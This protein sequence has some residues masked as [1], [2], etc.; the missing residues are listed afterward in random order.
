MSNYKG[1][2][3]K[4]EKVIPIEKADNIQ[5]AVVLGEFTIVSKTAKEGDVGILFP[6]GTQLSEQYCHENNLFRDSSK[7]KDAE[8]AGFFD[9]NRKV[10]C[11]KFLGVKSEAYF[12]TLESVAY[13]GVDISALTP[14]LCF[15]ELNGITICTKFLSEKAKKEKLVKQNKPKVKSVPFFKE[16]VETEQFKYNL[17]KINKGDLISIQSKRHGT[18]QRSGIQLV[19]K[20]LPKWKQHVNKFISLFKAGTV[21]EHVVGTRRVVLNTP[22][23]D[24][25]HGSEAFR[26]EIA[27]LILPFLSEGVTVY[28]EVYGWANG[29]TIMP[30]HN[31]EAIK[32]KEYQKKYGK[33][34]TYSYGCLEGTYGFH[35]YRV[36]YTTNSGEIVDLTQQ[37]LVK[38]CT[39]RGLNPALDVVEPFI[40]DG[41][42][43]KLKV[44]VEQLTER[45]EVLT[46]DYTDPKHVSEGV[47]VRIDRGPTTPLFL[48]SKSF[49]FRCLEGH[50]QDTG[51][52]DLEEVS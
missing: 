10:R 27:N 25:F 30:K 34:V 17:H 5:I 18:S 36:T 20:Q 47:I 2:V 19:T 29:K 6:S 22:E 45:P 3:S 23:K 51:E 32:N 38:W 16:H 44:L 7:N 50:V 4:I 40:Y 33:E 28:C 46:E 49:I 26:F 1:I 35:I 31:L 14:L 43:E 21:Y 39:D 13:T 52:V 37:Q 24:G 41:D 9:E 42:E 15:E 8:K 48:K 12:T 11:Q